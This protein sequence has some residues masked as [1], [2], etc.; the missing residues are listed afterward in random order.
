VSPWAGIALGPFT[1]FGS[2]FPSFH[3]ARREGTG[4][5]VGTNAAAVYIYDLGGEWPPSALAAAIGSACPFF[6]IRRLREP[7]R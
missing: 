3:P 6:G 5:S 7:D 2:V 4:G 1:C